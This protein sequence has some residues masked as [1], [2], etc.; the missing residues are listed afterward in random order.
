MSLAIYVPKKMA[1]PVRLLIL[2]REVACS[3]LTLDTD[4]LD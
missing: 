3:N 1:D 4:N 2:I